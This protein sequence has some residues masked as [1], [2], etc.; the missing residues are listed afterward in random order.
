LDIVLLGG[1]FVPHCGQNSA[2]VVISVP[3]FEQRRVILIFEGKGSNFLG[4][5]PTCLKRLHLQMY[6]PMMTEVTGPRILVI[7]CPSNRYWVSKKEAVTFGTSKRKM[8]NSCFLESLSKMKATRI[9]VTV[10]P[11][12][13]K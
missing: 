9:T 11:I 12:K 7:G 1:S 2:F 3:H 13:P 8:L 4:S 5:D 6:M 10:D